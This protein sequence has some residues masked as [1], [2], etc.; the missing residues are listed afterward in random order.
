MKKNNEPKVN[1][2]RLLE[3]ALKIADKTKICQNSV[4]WLEEQI[5]QISVDFDALNAGEYDHLNFLEKEE[6]SLNISRR[7][8]TCFS[9]NRMEQKLLDSLESEMY[10]LDLKI[11]EIDSAEKED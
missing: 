2:V 8:R 5:E 9:K 11:M 3:R 10:S 4:L 7:M 6:F 1:P